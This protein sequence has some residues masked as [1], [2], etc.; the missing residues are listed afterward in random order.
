VAL[1]PYSSKW[2]AGFASKEAAQGLVDKWWNATPQARE[3]ASTFG[4]QYA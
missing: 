2:Q 3:F 1:D 4:G